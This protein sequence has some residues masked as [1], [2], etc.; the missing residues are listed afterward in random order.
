M[1]WELSRRPD[2]LHRLQAEIDEASSDQGMIPDLQVL[3]RLP[4]LEAFFKECQST[5]QSI[6]FL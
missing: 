3:L 1:F 6:L 5:R 4:Y 2:I